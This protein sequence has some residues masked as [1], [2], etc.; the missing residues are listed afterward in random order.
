MSGLRRRVVRSADVVERAHG[1]AY[2]QGWEDAL[3][4]LPC[5]VPP[6][7]RGDEHGQWIDGWEAGRNERDAYGKGD[8]G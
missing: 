1:R 2:R 7:L 5:L 8:H 6:G 3:A 4:G